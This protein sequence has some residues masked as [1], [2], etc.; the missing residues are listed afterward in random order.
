[1]SWFHTAGGRY[2]IKD[3]WLGVDFARLFLEDRNVADSVFVHEYVHSVLAH[4]D[5]SQGT[6]TVLQNVQHFEHLDD[7]QREEISSLLYKAQWFVQEGYAS[8]MQTR[9]LVLKIGKKNALEWANNTFHPTYVEALKKYD[10]VFG[11]SSR[12]QNAFQTKVTDLALET[13]LRK[14]LYEQ[15]LLSS[16]DALK[17]Y[18]EDPQNNPDKRMEMILDYVKLHPHIVLKDF[19]EIADSVGLT[20]HPNATKEE[21]AKFLTYVSGMTAHPHQYKASDVG[22]ATS[23][24]DKMRTAHDSMVVTNLNLDL[25]ETGEFLFKMEDFLHYSDVYGIVFVNLQNGDI[26]YREVFD[27]LSDGREPDISLIGQ[28]KDGEKYLTLCSLD[29]AQQLLSNE[30]SPVTTIVKWGGYDAVNG[31]YIWS[32]DELRPRIVLYNSPSDMVENAKKYFETKNTKLKRLHIQAFEKGAIQMLVL[33]EP[34]TGVL[35]VALNYGDARIVK[36]LEQTKG[37]QEKTEVEELRENADDLNNFFY[38]LNM[39]RRINWTLTM[40]EQDLIRN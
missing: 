22:D 14:A 12:Y 10:F 9:F 18:L 5:F 2:D 20:F 35:H 27:L 4:S 25:A 29:E 6:R 11:M 16:P 33:K 15:D 8:Y 7:A 3:Q 32:Q 13:N 40:I 24:E 21:L 1:M 28:T 37:F 30:L 31:K 39:D 26:P 23:N 19:E 36:A 38:L 34:D 17:A